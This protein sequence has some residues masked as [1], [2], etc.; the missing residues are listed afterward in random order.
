M[1][2]KYA[3]IVHTV[4]NGREK[5]R[6]CLFTKMLTPVC[7]ASCQVMVVVY[8]L[9]CVGISAIEGDEWR[10]NRMVKDTFSSN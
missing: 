5:M 6:F 9:R 7:D 3:Y 1:N 2:L 10:L 4:I 8:L